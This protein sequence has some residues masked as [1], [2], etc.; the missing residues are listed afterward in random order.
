MIINCQPC[1]WLETWLEKGSY[2]DFKATSQRAPVFKETDEGRRNTCVK[3]DDHALDDHD[4]DDHDLDD[5]DLDDHALDDHDSDDDP[6]LLSWHPAKLSKPT[7]AENS[8]RISAS[9]LL[10]EDDGDD[11]D[12]VD[13]FPAYSQKDKI[14]PGWGN[15]R[16]CSKHCFQF[17]TMQCWTC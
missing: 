15:V 17:F 4:L 7:I 10:S 12:D 1:T 2:E 8:C 14:P 9:A 11:D 16:D 6:D 5:H 3:E 13:G